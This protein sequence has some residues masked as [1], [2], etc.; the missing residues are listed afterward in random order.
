MSTS[1]S[2]SAPAGA[3]APAAP[4]APE[5]V[6]EP[7]PFA[8][9]FL[10]SLL[11]L[12][13]C[14]LVGQ[15][16]CTIGEPYFLALKAGWVHRGWSGLCAAPVLYARDPGLGARDWIFAA[17]LLTGLVPLV[18]QRAAIRRF[19]LSM[20]CGVALVV[21]CITTISLGVLVPQIENFE[22]S[23]QR[24]TAQNRANEIERFVHAEGVFL[25]HLK[26]LYGIGAPRREIPPEVKQ[27]LDRF[28][29]LYGKEERDNR[30]KAMVEAFVNQAKAVEMQQFMEDHR[31]WLTTCFDVATAL[32]LNRAYKSYWFATLLTLLAFGVG[33]NLLRYSP[34]YWFSVHKA[35]FAVVHLG[36]LIMLGGG[37]VTKMC[38]DRGILHL[39][40][41]EGPQDTYERHYNR[42]K[43]ARMPF[44]LRL[45][46]FGRQDWKA[47]EVH[48]TAA[49][50]KSR[51]PR[52]TVWPNRTLDLD[53]VKDDRPGAE[54]DALRPRVRLTVAA[55]HDH[56]DI[57]LPRVTEQGVDAEY[58][59][60]LVDLETP[61][62]GAENLLSETLT[63]A[64]E[65][66]RRRMYLSPYL[67]S[68]AILHPRNEWRLRVAYGGD[69][70]SLFPS[71]EGVL[72]VLEVQVAGQERSEPELLPIQVGGSVKALGGYE[73]RVVDATRNFR[74]ERGPDGEQQEL[75]D[76]RPLDEQDEGAHAVWIEIHAPD[77]KTEKRLVL[78]AIDAVQHGMQT[79]YALEQV[80]TRLRWN[81]WSA[82]GGPRFVLAFG[83]AEQQGEPGA[84]ARLYDEL[85]RSFALAP[86]A[87]LPLP[88]DEAVV[89][90][91]VY[92]RARLEPD[93]RV[94]PDE[95]RADGW[96][97]DFYSTA[98]RGVE[99]DVIHD[100]GTAQEKRERIVM[101]TSTENGSHVWGS[102][103]GRF[104]LQ[105]VENSEMMPFEW[106]SVLSVVERTADG[107]PYVVPVGPEVDREIRVN[108]YFEY[109]GYRFFQTNADARYP[110][111]SGVG[112]V[113]DPGIPIV[114]LGMY[115]IIAG[116]AIAYILRP[117]VLARR[118]GGRSA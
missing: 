21:L 60:P 98:P 20:H 77:G 68:Q 57:R 24:V 71:D 5:A 106:R 26:H 34:K 79:T 109:G 55:L 90:K 19:F 13:G 46:R 64:P 32:H 85:G 62:I 23:E 110:T 69:A 89:L 92:E 52:Y 118:V 78:E 116:M 66:G 2:S 29:L 65:H 31:E 10:T 41:R 37:M 40:T 97:D 4:A 58:G 74:V 104:A 1:P 11:V 8:W 86:G 15:S 44:A 56:V 83:A 27:G 75:R 81:P 61:D 50:L 48:F 99:L 16:I 108:D 102:P 105:F 88:G 103:D 80:V 18:L 100:P 87:A 39:D 38:G 25:Y 72:G 76:T 101:A 22:D 111:Y 53:F 73:I 93:L 91:A 36:V 3:V 59:L 49:Q 17:G 35:G 96:D 28:G 82:P 9:G 113:Y 6:A 107:V 115:T 7:R 112:V 14:L 12:C 42:E 45:E 54:E 117:L 43:A 33:L 51:P 70:A 30:E 47:L 94:L 114:L 63:Q 67:P 84:K 95:P